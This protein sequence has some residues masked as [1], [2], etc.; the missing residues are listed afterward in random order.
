MMNSLGGGFGRV[1]PSCKEAIRLQSEALDRELPL[2]E[3]LG[4]RF[5]V[6]LCK[7]CRRYGQQIRFLREAVRKHAEDEPGPPA[8]ALSVAAK[9]RI[10]RMLR[11]EKE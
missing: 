8:Q 2:P 4:L 9:T 7:W 6:L 1:M 5:H 3:R 11:A 10:K